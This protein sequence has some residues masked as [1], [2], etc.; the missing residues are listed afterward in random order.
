MRALL[1]L[2]LLLTLASCEPPKSKQPEKA[3]ATPAEVPP[4]K[5]AP[6]ADIKSSVVRI[7]STLQSWNPAQPWEKQPP[8]Q[9]R[10][11]AAIVGPQRVLTTSEM[12][13]D[14]TYLEFES[15]DG[16]HFAQAKVIAVDYE[17]NLALLGPVSENEGTAMFEKTTPIDITAP[18]KIGQGLAILQIEE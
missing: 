2:P 16:T 7:N 14:A 1:T 18:P 13:A 9:R 5:T 10:A 12:V 6:L 11:L 4:A 8:G 17:A 3:A 15:P